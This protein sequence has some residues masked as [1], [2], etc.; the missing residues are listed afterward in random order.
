MTRQRKRIFLI[1]DDPAALVLS[2]RLF[3]RLDFE[4][5]LAFDNPRTAIKPFTAREP[6]PSW[7]ICACRE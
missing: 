4:A 2:Q 3:E 1:D 5:P 7:S 6:K